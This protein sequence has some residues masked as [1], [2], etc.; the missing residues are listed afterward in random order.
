MA[1]TTAFSLQQFIAS[2]DN[3]CLP[4]IL[5]VCSGVYFQ[6]SIYELSGSEVSFSTG[7]LIKVIGIELLSVCCE[8]ISNNKIFEL[9]INHTGLFKVVPDERPYSSVEEMVSMRPVGLE[10]CLPFTFICCSKI[11]IDNFTLGAK[12]AL[13][14]LSIERHEGEEDQV[15]CHIQGQEES[16]AEVCIPLSSQGEF[17]EC[18]SEERFTV[19]EIMS[20]PCLRSQ[21]FRFINT[22]KYERP[23]VLSPIYQVKAIMNLRKNVLKFPSSLEVDVVDVTELCKDVNF[24]TPLSLTDVLSQPVESFPAVVEILEVPET[25]SL[26]KCSWLPEFS[27]SSH[28]IFH[29]ISNS[30]MILLSSLKSRKAQ[31]YFLVAQQY[32]GRFRRRPREFNSVYELHVASIQAPGL[33][34]SVTRNCEEV[35][36]EG[37][38]ALSVGEQ[39]EVVRWETI[40]LPCE[41]NKGQ[42]RSVEALLCRLLQEHDD[43]DD[44]DDDDEDEVKQEDEREEIFLPLYMQGHFVEVLSDNK[45]YRLKDLGKELSLPLDVKVVSRDTELENDPLVG[46]ACLRI[47]GAMLE[48]TI[49]ASFAHRPDRCFEIPAQWLSMSVCFTKDPL[50]WSSSKPPKCHVDRVTEVT[51]LFFYEFHKQGSTDAAPPPRPPKRDL[52]SSKPS[53]KSSKPPKQSSKQQPDKSIPTKGLADLTL[54]SKRRP[55]APPPPDISNDQPPPTVPRKHSVDER[56]TGSA[57]PNAYVQRND[58]K[59][60]VHLCEVEANDD[61]DDDYETVDDSFVTDISNDQ[62]PPIVPRKHSVDERPTGSA[63]PNAYVQR[64]DLK[65]KVHLCEVEANDDSDHDYETVD[66]SFVTVI[67]NA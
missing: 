1:E 11:T 64:N 52:R 67:K 50:P 35:E 36:E 7:D 56:P 26:F 44:D 47:E 60:K 13:R 15:R 65:N 55:P 49:Q 27:K 54:N 20:S 53:K 29:K 41:S 14:V 25:C 9:P 4:K 63:L 34:V 31:Q 66:D 23:V 22:T 24:V 17:R 16:S 12:R 57:L 33:K 62:P 51:D 39:L 19:Q 40:E 8:D 59:N 42:K 61:S 28:L 2:L 30:A 5:Q 10:S 58:L 48:P 3:S 37:L 38:P 18:E 43:G 6:G 32:G 21:R 45:K 46:F